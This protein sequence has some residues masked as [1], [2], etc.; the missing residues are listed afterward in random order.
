LR[1]RR[2]M[3]NANEKGKKYHPSSHPKYHPRGRRLLT[4]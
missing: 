1:G 3:R 4:H 2:K